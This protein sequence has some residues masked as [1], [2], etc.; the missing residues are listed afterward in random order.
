MLRRFGWRW[1]WILTFG[2]LCLYIACNTLDVDG[3]EYDGRLGQALIS[4]AADSE[5]IEKAFRGD[6][7][8]WELIGALA[9]SA[10]S[11]CQRID[12]RPRLYGRR[13]C[14]LPRRSLAV[15]VPSASSAD[16]A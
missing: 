10:I 12:L 7:L 4:T 3:S 8:C 13:P 11:W 14:R 5:D 1:C 9:P 6:P 2:F 15:A 16:P